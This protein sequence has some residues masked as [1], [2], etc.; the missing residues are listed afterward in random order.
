M[1]YSRLAIQF[2]CLSPVVAVFLAQKVMDRLNELYQQREKGPHAY[3]SS[4]LATITLIP[5]PY[6]L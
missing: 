5:R 4:L 3:M 6:S 2:Y 1:L